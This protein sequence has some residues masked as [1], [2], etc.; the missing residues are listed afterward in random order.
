MAVMRIFLLCLLLVPVSLHAAIWYVSPAGS[1]SN[2][3]DN[4]DEPCQTLAGALAK[5]GVVAGDSIFLA[6]GVYTNSSGCHITISKA[7]KIVGGYSA[8]FSSK[9]EDASKTVFTDNRASGVCRLF[10]VNTGHGE[11]LEFNTVQLSGFVQ[12]GSRTDTG[13]VHTYSAGA[14]LRFVNV[15][16]RDNTMAQAAAIESNIAGDRL[17]VIASE[18]ANNEAHTGVAGA[19]RIKTGGSFLIRDSVIHGNRA[20]THGGALYITPDAG[21][22]VTDVEMINVTL[23]GNS[24]GLEAGAVWASGVT[25]TVRCT[26]CSIVGNTSES[27][28]E[29]EKNIKATSGARLYFKNS[30][31]LNDDTGASA[32][33]N[34]HLSG[35][36]TLDS[37]GYNA[38]G[39]D[40]EDGFSAGIVKAGSDIDNAEANAINIVQSSV[41]YNGGNI[42]SLKPVSSSSLIDAIPNDL[43][44]PL[45]GISP[46]TPFTSLAQAHSAIAYFGSY[47]AG[48][49]Y[50]EIDGQAFRSYVDDEG[51]VLVASTDPGTLSSSLTQTSNV[52]LQGDN[53]L[54][55]AV[56]AVLDADEIRISA[57]DSKLG[58]F[59]MR[60]RNLVNIA[61]LKGNQTLGNNFDL[62]VKSWSGT[63]EA[64]MSNATC[65]DFA[66]AGISTQL[67]DNVIGHCGDGTQGLHWQG[68][69]NDGAAPDGIES[70]TWATA[71]P[72]DG[73]NLWVRSFGG[74]CN[75]IVATDQRS[76]PRPDFV[77]PNDPNQYGDIRDCDIGSFE[78]S[79][80]YRLDCHAEDGERPQN[81]LD[82][83]AISFCVSS[84]TQ[85]TPKAIMD[86]LGRIN[87]P[88]LMLALTLLLFRR[89]TWAG[90][91]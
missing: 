42:R 10:A 27:P 55:P 59:D 44:P 75:G 25:T 61:R 68:Q 85:I 41:Q 53:I 64:N 48:R 57:P 65:S 60:S 87:A 5:P 73:L 40:S 49:Y 52:V 6:Q 66:H 32:G 78:W 86:N 13:L 74:H 29:V 36:A 72:R 15:I 62:G 9:S 26:H 14:W 20:Q 12:E 18:I 46:S 4:T 43:P 24:A 35:G 90:K 71:L 31:V 91:Q 50:F 23:F 82:F 79:N 34:V 84:P 70:V 54:S 88:W 37:G 1:N 17:E 77:N 3:C 28:A 83:S 45:A 16:I 39:I 58:N 89:L 22:R 81:S 11:Y 38:F 80:G 7:V 19:I 63:H 30:L 21:G 8:D 67:Q 76:M 33:W 69:R 51:F 2:A 47:S 56:L